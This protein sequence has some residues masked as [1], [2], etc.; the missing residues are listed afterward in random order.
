MGGNWISVANR[1]CIRRWVT[2]HNSIN[3]SLI[4][5]PYFPWYRLY[6]HSSVLLH[7]LESIKHFKI[8]TSGSIYICRL[9]LYRKGLSLEETIGRNPFHATWD[10]RK[11]TQAFIIHRHML[12]HYCCVR[13]E[14]CKE[15]KHSRFTHCCGYYPAHANIAVISWC[16]FVFTYN[17]DVQIYIPHMLYWIFIQNH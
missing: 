9:R 1:N 4:R 3:V 16:N 7:F 14:E 11:G 6:V 17:G 5:G 8:Y 13:F 2:V 10:D 15:P 12:Y